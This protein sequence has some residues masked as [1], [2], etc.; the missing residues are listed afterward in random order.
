M[1]THNLVK[2]LPELARNGLNVKVV[3]AIS[4]QLF[5]SQDDSYRQS[6]M[7]AAD[8]V[9]SMV[10]TSGAFKLMHQWAE[11]PITREYSLSADFDDRWRT[12]GTVDE[13]ISEAHLGSASILVRDRA[14]RQPSGQCGC[15]A[16]RLTWTPRPAASGSF[17][18]S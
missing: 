14:L 4:P 10:V 1:P 17:R 16:G 11:G 8:S 9:D 5:R 15:V 7:S 2:V 12:G 3:A 18:A 13:V 6:V